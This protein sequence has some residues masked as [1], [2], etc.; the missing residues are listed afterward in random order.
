MQGGTTSEEIRNG[1]EH[2]VSL[3][4]QLFPSELFIYTRIGK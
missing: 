2:G 3:S 4:Y 1:N